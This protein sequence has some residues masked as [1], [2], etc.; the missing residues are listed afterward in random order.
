MRIKKKSCKSL[1]STIIA[2]NQK[3]EN[4]KTTTTKGSHKTK[5]NKTKKTYITSLTYLLCYYLFLFM[6]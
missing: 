4:K 2:K 1:Y 6:L 5:Q 3:N